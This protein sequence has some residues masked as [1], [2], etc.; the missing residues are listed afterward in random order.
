MTSQNVLPS[1]MQ[2]LP[3]NPQCIKCSGMGYRR[4]TKTAN[5]WKGCKL[6]AQQYGTDLSSVIIP[7]TAN[8]NIVYT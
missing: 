5:Q 1:G 2:T 4:S 3:A 8:Q 7:T 6:C